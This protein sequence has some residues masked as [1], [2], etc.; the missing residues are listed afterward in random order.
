MGSR[1]GALDGLHILVAEDDSD[2]RDILKSVLTYFGAHV[3]AV[4]TVTSARAVLRRWTPDVVI[5]DMFLGSSDGIALLREARKTGTAAPF[6]AV[7]GQDFDAVSLK[8]AG[9]AAYLR[10]PLDHNTLVDAILDLV[11]PRKTG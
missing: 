10:K 2:A 5:A 6:I 11:H 1:Q 9:F 3:E 4:S 7:S 8:A